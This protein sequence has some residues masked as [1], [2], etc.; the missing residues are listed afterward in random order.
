MEKQKGAPRWAIDFTRP[1]FVSQINQPQPLARAIEGLARKY[2]LIVVDSITK[3]AA[4]S[5]DQAI[6]EFFSSCKRL[7]SKAGTIVVVIQPHAIDAN[8]RLRFHSIC[9][10]HFNLRSGNLG[11]KVIRTLRVLKANNVELS[12]NNSVS[13]QME[14]GVGM[15]VLSMASV[16]A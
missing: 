11:V 3:L 6:I 5:Q 4:S 8:T 10:N 14:P 15:R 13:F 12:T 9:D 2:E 16:R 1:W 7:C